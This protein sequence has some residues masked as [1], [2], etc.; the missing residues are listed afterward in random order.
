MIKGIRLGI[1][2]MKNKEG[3]RNI[4]HIS[5][6]IIMMARSMLLASVYTILLV[7][8]ETR[9][10]VPVITIAA[11]GNKVASFSSICYL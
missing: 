5:P 6:P 11:L 4:S 8:S 1:S 7:R 2:E 9:I 10:F 3:L